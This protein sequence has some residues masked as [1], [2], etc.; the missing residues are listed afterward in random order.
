MNVQ[1]PGTNLRTGGQ[2]RR[3]D[4]DTVKRLTGFA[5]GGVP[6]VGHVSPLRILVDE[7]LLRCPEVWAAAGTPHH[8]FGIHPRALV[9]ASAGTVADDVARALSNSPIWSKYQSATSAIDS[10][11]AAR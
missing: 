10:P 3:A 5:V 8:N 1:K 7:D 2:V 11:R 4:A 9:E 6:P